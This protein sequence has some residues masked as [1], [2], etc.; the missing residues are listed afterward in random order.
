MK[1]KVIILVGIFIFV[2]NL[3][4]AIE[5]QEKLTRIAIASS[6]AIKY[7]S[8]FLDNPPRFI[9]RFS[10]SNV[11]GKLMKDTLLNEGVIKNITVT[12]Y[13]DKVLSSDRKKIKF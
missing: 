10:T 5:S 12:Y 9:I 13:P 3:T 1:I 7:E 8:R 6:D 4:Q 2:H 11:F